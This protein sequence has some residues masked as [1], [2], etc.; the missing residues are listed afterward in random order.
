MDGIRT[1]LVGA[2]LYLSQHPDEATYTDSAATA[3]LVDGLRVRTVGPAG[4]T[5]MTD[6]PT[7]VG[8]SASA[9]SA[10]WVLRAA[11]ASCVATVVAMRAAQLGHRL[12]TLT[13]TVDSVSDDRGILGL[14]ASIP[15]GPLRGH[16]AISLKAAGVA[17]ADLEGIARWGVDHCPVVDAVRRAVPLT[18]DVVTEP[19]G[20]P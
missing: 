16:I 12:E 8:G 4:A 6:M 14:D 11:E 1:A 20:Q 18:V 15:A 9:P 3:T 7:S 19:I 2:T 17:T 10:G 13:V 5:V